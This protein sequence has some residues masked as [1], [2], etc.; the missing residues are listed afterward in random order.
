MAEGGEWV[1]QSLI[2]LDLAGGVIQMIISPD[3]MGDGHGR[4]IHNN[5]K[6]IRGEPI[7][8]QDDQIIQLRIIKFHSA[9]N[10]IL[11]HRLPFVWREK[12]NRKGS[13]WTD[14]LPVKAGT[15]IFGFESRFQS[16]L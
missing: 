8:S 6:I 4:I 15:T 1:V 7:T 13:V 3:D 16:R 12:P 2:N 10:E 9:L 5:R 11:H 14:H